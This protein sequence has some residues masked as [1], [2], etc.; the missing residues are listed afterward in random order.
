MDSNEPKNT[1]YN[2]LE[3]MKNIKN[4]QEDAQR[5]Q[6]TI[7]ASQARNNFNYKLYGDIDN[8]GQESSK[9]EEQ[10]SDATSESQNKNDVESTSKKKGK[11]LRRIV[12]TL[13]GGTASGQMPEELFKR[14]LAP[15]KRLLMIGGASFAI[16]MVFLLFA[17]SSLLSYSENNRHVTKAIVKKFSRVTNDKDDYRTKPGELSTKYEK[18]DVAKDDP[19]KYF[20]KNLKE[21]LI[22]YLKDNGY[23]PTDNCLKSDAY[24]FYR[25]LLLTVLQSE[26]DGKSIDVGLLYETMAYHRSDDEL[27]KGSSS[28]TTE[29]KWWHNIFNLFSKKTDEMDTLIN[30]MF[31]GKS[32][33]LNH[34]AAYLLYG[35]SINSGSS[36]SG[37]GEGHVVI[38]NANSMADAM[39]KLALEQEGIGESGENHNKFTEWYG[40]DGPWCAMFVSWVIAHTE[41]KGD[42]LVDSIPVKEAAVSEMLNWFKNNGNGIKFYLNDHCSLFKGVKGSGTYTPKRGDIIFFYWNPGTYDGVG[43]AP[44]ADNSHVGIVT[45]VEG[46]KV[47]TIEGNSSN[48]VRQKAYALDSC[49]IVGYGSWY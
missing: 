46:N 23:C 45:D 3:T 44:A 43:D 37:S 15:I 30:N 1:D 31:T 47:S 11:G 25:K 8:A 10:V 17:V 28:S 19:E 2:P 36:S 16:L 22:T 12:S 35:N 38:K 13:S 5:I 20:E 49:S 27:F 21:E 32:L 39:A 9:S 41:Y 14:L 40:F 24:T 48:S 7:A 34:Y 33:D 26:K 29:T 42:K 18:F 6:E 4:N